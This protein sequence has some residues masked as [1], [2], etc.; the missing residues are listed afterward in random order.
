MYRRPI[1]L[2]HSRVTTVRRRM[3]TEPIYKM[4]IF[5]IFKC[6]NKENILEN[7]AF[8]VEEQG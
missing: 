6:L 3:G 5:I 4:S 1:L 8:K 2:R 7:K